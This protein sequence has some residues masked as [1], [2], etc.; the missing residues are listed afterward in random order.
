MQIKNSQRS[1]VDHKPSVRSSELHP[2]VKRNIPDV[3]LGHCI[4]VVSVPLE[5]SVKCFIRLYQKLDEISS[6]S[7]SLFPSSIPRSSSNL[8]SPIF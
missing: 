2:T 7:L 5:G 1:K 8:K 4:L 3:A 6:P